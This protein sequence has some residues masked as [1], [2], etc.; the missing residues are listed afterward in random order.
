MFA[1]CTAKIED[2]IYNKETKKSKLVLVGLKD[3]TGVT[4]KRKGTYNY[5]TGNKML[6]YLEKGDFIEFEAKFEDG[7]LESISDAKI[8]GDSWSTTFANIGIVKHPKKRR[9][10][11]RLANGDL[12]E[13]KCDKYGA[14]Y[15]YPNSV[16]KSENEKMRSKGKL[17][18][19]FDINY[20]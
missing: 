20:N 8:I 9:Y 1:R 13:L 15:G 14:V 3:S 7:E 6:R 5:W 12:V 11:T 2:N 10:F 16:K 17:G 19:F 18:V 4:I